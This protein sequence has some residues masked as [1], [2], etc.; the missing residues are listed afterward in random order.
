[1][2]NTLAHI[3][4]NADDVA[5]AKQ[6]YEAVF[7]WRFEPYGPPEF[8][9]IHGLG[10]RGALQKRSQPFSDRHDSVECSFAVENLKKSE[11]MIKNAGGAVIGSQY[12]IPDVGELVKFRDTEN[13]E[14][15]IIQFVADI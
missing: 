10:I 5:R 2:F 1:M 9:L 11:E 6:F 13:N 14:M 15:I 8:Y 12:A 4:I 3:A 7:G